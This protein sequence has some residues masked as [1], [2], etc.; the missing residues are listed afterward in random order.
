MVYEPIEILLG[1]Y[2]GGEA[3]N[4]LLMQAAWILGLWILERFV[5]HRVQ[6]AIEI[7][8]G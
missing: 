6:T 2:R 7:Q 8:G 3:I 4:V 5:W 1:E